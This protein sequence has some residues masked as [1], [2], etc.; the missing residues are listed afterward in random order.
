MQEHRE[1]GQVAGLL[2]QPEEQVEAEHHRHHDAEGEEQAGGQQAEFGVY[3]GR[4]DECRWDRL[5]DRFEEG[6]EDAGEDLVVEQIHQIGRAERADEEVHR[7]E[8]RERDRDAGREPLGPQPEAHHEQRRALL[9]LLALAHE[10]VCRRRVA[11]GQNH[12]ERPIEIPAER[13]DQ[14]V[15][16]I[17]HALAEVLLDVLAR[18]RRLGQQQDGQGSRRDR[19]AGQQP[20]DEAQHV[21]DR[22][23]EGNRMLGALRLLEQGRELADTTAFQRHGGEDR[24]AQ[25]FFQRIARDL[26]APGLGH[27]HHV[28]GEDGG[29][30]ELGQL[31][32]D[33]QG[34]AQVLRVE[35][36]HQRVELPGEQELARD[37]SV[38]AA[39]EDGVHPGSVDDPDPVRRAREEAVLQVADRNLDRGARKREVAAAGAAAELIAQDRLAHRHVAHHRRGAERLG[40]G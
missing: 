15:D 13:G 38:L 3:E 19:G 2:E 14:A 25:P 29:K 10:A 5:D 18:R 7:D 37:H 30:L 31:E 22:C 8:N 28:Q 9:N 23:G 39:G 20:A 34:A 26:D 4:A 27:V 21:F 6:R 33:D 24:C 40:P 1:A 17:D 36:L 12:V 32:G 16:L 35:H 11:L